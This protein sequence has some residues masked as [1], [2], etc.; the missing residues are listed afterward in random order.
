MTNSKL[1]AAA[2][3]A[4][5]ATIATPVLADVNAMPDFGFT[6]NAPSMTQTDSGPKSED[7]ALALS[8]AGTLAGPALMAAAEHMDN[9]TTKLSLDSAGL[10]LSAIGPS[11][12]HWYAGQASGGAIALRTTG[13]LLMGTGIAMEILHGVSLV[14]SD[15]N[16]PQPIDN[17][18][19]STA[20]IA[21]VAIG[22]AALVGGTIYDLVTSRHAAREYNQHH[23]SV[24]FAPMMSRT[25][26]GGMAT[27]VALNGSF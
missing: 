16:G 21:L 10:L 7:A 27:G 23:H 2:L 9:G 12:G 6:S 5:F 19:D 4:A 3:V 22:G 8:I 15:D 20:G 14:S 17:H 13:I 26:T 24:Q 25:T 18:T 11:A 1:T